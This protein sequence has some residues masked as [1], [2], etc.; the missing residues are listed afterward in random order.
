MQ[1]YSF[2]SSLIL[3]LKLNFLF[4]SLSSQRLFSSQS[5]KN[6]R[7]A[8]NHITADIDPSD[9]LK[10]VKT[11]NEIINTDPTNEIKVV[12]YK[13]LCKVENLE[14]GLRRTKSGVSAG[15]DGEVRANYTTSK[16]EKLAGELKSHSYKPSPIKNV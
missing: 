2:L 15:L 8:H 9:T 13:D 7:G 6:L 5:G 16:L 3:K 11:D 4:H 12:S 14:L 10:A 1:K